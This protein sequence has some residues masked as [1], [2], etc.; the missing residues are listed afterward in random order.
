[1]RIARSIQRTLFTIPDADGA[2]VLQMIDGYAR[3]D[4]DFVVETILNRVCNSKNSVRD[5]G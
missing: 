1:M 3:E 4:R 5:H 2:N